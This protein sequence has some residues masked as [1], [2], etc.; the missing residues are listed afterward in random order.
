[1][2]A[3]DHWQP[4]NRDAL[5]ACCLSDDRYD[6]MFQEFPERWL[7]S[8]IA[9]T[10]DRDAILEA[11]SIAFATGDQ[12]QRD[13]AFQIL[14]AAGCHSEPRFIDQLTSAVASSP[15]DFS[16]YQVGDLA[17]RTD[18]E[19]FVNWLPNCLP[20]DDEKS[21]WSYTIRMED[22]EEAH[23]RQIFD[24]KDAM[25]RELLEYVPPSKWPETVELSEALS[26]I[27]S[28]GTVL[29]ARYRQPTDDQ[30]ETVERLL[31]RESQPE[32][33]R[34]LLRVLRRRGF[35]HAIERGLELL[36]HSDEQIV[37]RAATALSATDDPRVAAKGRELATHPETAA[38][39]ITVAKSSLGPADAEFCLGVFRSVDV[40]DQ[41]SIAMSLRPRI[42]K[43]RSPL[44][45]DL[46]IEL[47]AES[48]CTTCREGLCELIFETGAV[49]DWLD[50]EA[51]YN[52]LDQDRYLI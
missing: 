41:H 46:L 33:I 42:D 50:A 19:V 12:L 37:R 48:R 28:G 39:G 17:C 30:A 11:L 26:V 51:P 34:Y 7:F 13:C 29:H 4:E 21:R 47:Y 27:Q 5:V 32:N 44:W 8:L 35:T 20:D 14:L 40:D 52:A 45:H 16:V 6:R 38:L 22:I 49:P 36:D 43:H 1:L 3:R 23:G 31:E 10:S 18:P 24:R 2:H 25:V 15:R 9:V